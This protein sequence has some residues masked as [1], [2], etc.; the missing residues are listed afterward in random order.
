MSTLPQPLLDRDLRDL[1]EGLLRLAGQVEAQIERATFALRRLDE[2]GARELQREDRRINEAQGVL[3]ERCFAIIATRRPDDRAL[4]LLMSIQYICVELE[5]MG[6]YAARMARRTCVLAGLPT[7][8]PLRAEFGLMG[9]LATQQV[10]DILDALIETDAERAR[11][12]AA[13]DAQIDRL[14]DRAFDEVVQELA[15]RGAEEEGSDRVLRAVTLLQVAH[16]LERI[17]DRVTNVAEDIV[18]LETGEVVE[19]G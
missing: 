13:Q 17:G 18:F 14:Y 12:I 2:G 5:R 3:R 19:L 11:E 16:D 15:T 8:A 9:E 10:R 7:R 4:R 6:D 1:R